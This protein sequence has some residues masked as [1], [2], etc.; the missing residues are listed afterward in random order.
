MQK[1]KTSK[2]LKSHDTN[3]EESVEISGA[4]LKEL[5]DVMSTD[6]KGVLSGENDPW[7][8]DKRTGMPIM[9]DRGEIY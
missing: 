5:R 4:A 6:I 8:T 2:E 1:I 3:L 9:E 7:V